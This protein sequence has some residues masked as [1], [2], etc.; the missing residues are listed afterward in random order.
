VTALLLDSARL[1]DEKA[2]FG[3]GTTAVEAEAKRPERAAAPDLNAPL[4]ERFLAVVRR[5][6]DDGEIDLPLFDASTCELVSLLWD[7]DLDAETLARRLELDMG[8]SSH[9]LRVANSAR[10]APVVPITSLQLAVT[11]LGLSG[12]RDSVLAITVKNKAFD[13]PQWNDTVRGIW[14]RSAVRSGFARAIG[15][16]SEVGTTRGTMAALLL[17][18]GKPAILNALPNIEAELGEELDRELA[19]LLVDEVH[20]EVGAALVERWNLPAWLRHVVRFQSSPELAPSHQLDTWLAHLADQF[21]SWSESP[22]PARVEAL[23][24]G[25]G[26]LELC[27]FPDAGRE[28]LGQAAAIREQA[29]VY[30]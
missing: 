12:V 19:L 16:A 20:A 25:R 1:A 24:H 29:S 26:C 28:I 22:D 5:L 2:H 10:N 15:K 30:D 3:G 6:V 14:S 13:V 17:D 21:A 23:I 4:E 8:V 18:V 11:R 27:I 7:E 9:L